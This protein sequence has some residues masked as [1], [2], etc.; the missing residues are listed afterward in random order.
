MTCCEPKSYGSP[1]SFTLGTSLSRYSGY[2]QTPLS[3][4]PSHAYGTYLCG[5]NHYLSLIL[6]V[7]RHTRGPQV[8]NLPYRS[9]QSVFE[10]LVMCCEMVVAARK[11]PLAKNCCLYRKYKPLLRTLAH[12]RHSDIPTNTLF[13]FIGPCP[14]KAWMSR[15]LTDRL[16]CPGVRSATF[17]PRHHPTRP[18]APCPTPPRLVPAPHPPGFQTGVAH[19]T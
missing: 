3:L 1:Y 16:A 2:P 8:S 7:L 9:S 10:S 14:L 13:E 15:L 19:G 6:T 12:S 5:K 18:A 17:S 4:K 11:A